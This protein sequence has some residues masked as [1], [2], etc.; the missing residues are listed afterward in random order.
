MEVEELEQIKNARTIFE[1]IARTSIQR[2]R[3]YGSDHHASASGAMSKSCKIYD[4]DLRDVSD[5]AA[6][7]VIELDKVLDGNVPALP[8]RRNLSPWRSP[9]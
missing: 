1:R 6:E 4:D 2:C 3:D 8:I 7:L 5:E 9:W